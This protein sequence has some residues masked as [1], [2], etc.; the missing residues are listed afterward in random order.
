MINLVIYSLY[1]HC[2]LF[3]D[4]LS[5]LK[6]LAT[7]SNIAPVTNKQTSSGIISSS[8]TKVSRGQPQQLQSPSIMT[9]VTIAES[10]N[11]RAVPSRPVLAVKP[12]ERIESDLVRKRGGGMVAVVFVQKLLFFVCFEILPLR[13]Y[14]AKHLTKRKSTLL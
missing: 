14:R 9:A 4:L 7:N 11:K 2:F 13:V 1:T 3:Q 8:K 5:G 10:T 12:T 6:D